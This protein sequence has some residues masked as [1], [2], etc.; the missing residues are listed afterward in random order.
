MITFLCPT[1]NRPQGLRRLI[2]SAVNH[3]SGYMP[4]SFGFYIDEDDTISEEAINSIRKE[5]FASIWFIRGPRLH[6][7]SEASNILARATSDGIMF[8]CGDD[9]EVTTLN[10]DRYVYEEFSKYNDKILLVYGDDGIQHSKLATHF[11]IHKN[12]VDTL[13]H[14]L[15]PVFTGDWVD[16]WVTEVSTSLGRIKYLSDVKLPHHHCTVGKSP[17]D[18]TY[19]EKFN[20]DRLHNP[21]KVFEDTKSLRLNDITKLK[22][23]IDNHGKA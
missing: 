21:A 2:H 8:F 14:V 6:Q 15:P 9:V 4:I 5:T 11:F 10:W 16:N 13:G 23:F 7:L 22:Q 19:I 12:W 1:R 18:L 20:K 3:S 17:V